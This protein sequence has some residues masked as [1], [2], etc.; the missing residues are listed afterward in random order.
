VKVLD[1]KKQSLPGANVFIKDSYDGASSSPDG[2][3]SFTANDTGMVT[4]VTS[5]IGYETLEK[6]IRL[7]GKELNYNP[8]LKEAFNEL[9]L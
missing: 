6:K 2:T 3:Y 7:T 4:I 1:Q 8:V 5:F 9:K